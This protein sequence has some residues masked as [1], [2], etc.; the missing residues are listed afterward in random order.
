MRLP[1]VQKSE[2]MYHMMLLF[3]AMDGRVLKYI[4]IDLLNKVSVAE[5]SSVVA[6]LIIHDS[7]NKRGKE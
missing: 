5:Q 3:T 6:Y 1:R 7:H 4:P 2:F